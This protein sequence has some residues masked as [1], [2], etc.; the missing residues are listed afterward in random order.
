MVWP[1]GLR[2]IVSPFPPPVAARDGEEGT[3]EGEFH[4]HPRY[5]TQGTLDATMLQRVAGGDE[6]GLEKVHDALAAHLEA[7]RVG[8]TAPVIEVA[9]MGH[10]LGA[11]FRG[12][13]LIPAT[14]EVVSDRR[15]VRVERM[16]FHSAIDHEAVGFLHDWRASLTGLTRIETAEFQ[17]IRIG[18]TGAAGVSATVRYELV[19][20]GAGFHR[21]QRIGHWD[22]EWESGASGDWR[23]RR[24]QADV[25]ERSRS[26]A[27]VFADVSDKTLGRSASYREHLLRGVDYW[28]TVLDGASGIDLYGH[29]GVSLGDID[30]DG[31]DDL[32]VCQPAGLPNRLYRNL[33][34]GTFEDI[35]E[36][37]GTG[38]LDNSACALIAD[39]DNDGRQD[40]V[41]VRANGPLLFLNQGGGKFRLKPNAFQF[42]NTPQGTFVGAAAAD[43]DR[44][45]RLDI[46]FCLYVY[47]QGTD[48]YK[49]PVP[50][51]DA[52][53]GPPNFLMRNNGDGTFRDVTA[54]AGLDKNNNR[55]SFCCGWGD[56]NG[57]G[58]PDLYVVNDFGRKNLYRNNGDGTFTD[59]AGE[60]GVEDTGAGMSVC[61]LDY[62]NDGLSDLYVGNMWTAAG[63]RITRQP[64]FQSYAPEQTRALYRKHAMG[65][66]LFSNAGAQRFED[67]TRESR[68]GVGRWAWSSDAWD[69]DHDGFP[70]VYIVNGMISGP[71]RE[72][73]NSFFWR[74]VVAQSPETAK[75]SPEYEHGWHAINELIRAD[76]SWS[77]YERNIFYVNNRDGT[78]SNVSGAIGLDFAEDGRSFA[79]GDVDHDGRQEIFLKNRNAPQLRVM[80]NVMGGLAPAIAF[81]LRG[82]KSHGDAIGAAVTIETNRGKQTKWLQA[83]SGF[84][85]QHSKEI[86]FGLG[87]ATGTVKATIRWPSGVVQTIDGLP[88]GH[89]VWVEESAFRSPSAWRSEPFRVPESLRGSSEGAASSQASGEMGEEQRLPRNVETWLLA[90]V[91][92]PDFA[93]DDGPGAAKSLA[94][95]RGK[96][97]LLHLRAAGS[98]ESER[99][100]ANLERRRGKWAARGLQL[101]SVDVSGNETRL[102]YPRLHSPEDVGAVYNLLYRYL[103]ERHR[104]LTLP[105]S[106]LI[107]ERGNVVKLYQGPVDADHVESDF[108]GMPRT[109]A[110]RLKPALPFPGVANSY[111]F[112]RNQLSY[113]SVFYQHGYLDQAEEAFRLALAE[114]SAS[115]E[116]Y[117]GLGSVFLKRGNAAEAKVNFERAASLKASYPETLPNAWN[118]LGL[119]ATRE[120]RIDLAIE[121]FQQALRVS[122]EHW[123][124]LENLGN[125]YRQEKRW[126]EARS[127]LE[128][129]LSNRPE[130]AEANYSLA[131]VYAQTE[132]PERA[133]EYLERALRYRPAYPEALNNLGILCLRTGKRDDAVAQFEECIRVAPEFDQAYLNLARVYA[134]EGS[135]DKAQSVLEALLKLQPANAAARQ[136]LEQMR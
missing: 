75:A 116:A 17:I 44:D 13:S 123:I 5:R 29:N 40:L 2:G 117:Y 83:G 61:W 32:Y 101:L 67:A 15:G 58:W 53:N 59:V 10:S 1:G 35:T 24:W 125:A 135:R 92:A 121:N 119:L 80:K 74:Q 12:V 27:P 124:A 94:A 57:D 109:G 31:F 81:R 66:S 42:A 118:N 105:T 7:W 95:L 134:I 46:Y 39:F 16:H 34:D 128:R 85:A 88:S 78:F 55:Y 3:A 38:I 69:F 28:R 72:D 50:Y 132:Q 52:Q 18:A 115:A 60:A 73:L 64:M 48:Q 133:R 108:P 63:E 107:D 136:A 87:E 102:P 37:S 104:D 89:R 106:F 23:I 77:G 9:A 4:L 26:T 41:V 100:R 131:M 79:L 22:L 30:G 84:L 56:Y 122:P 62:D 126:G 103:Y 14:S 112:G 49:Y 76:Y 127:T 19:A 91:L 6:F 86:F 21:E 97:V 25:E 99:D 90:P 20:S 8:L 129:A 110:E 130:D 43:Y 70:D 98:E 54:E 11:Q 68:L 36:A 93:F 45:G 82:T 96:P 114:D 120:G 65:N 33:G 47:Y 111:E 51:Y 113:G 71:L